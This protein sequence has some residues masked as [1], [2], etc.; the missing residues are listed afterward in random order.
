ATQEEIS[1]AYRRFSRIFHPDKHSSDP[2]KQKWAEQIFNK[3][4]EAYEVLS[5]SHK[6]AIYDTLGK[7]GLEV[8]GWEII[9]RTRTPREI[10]EEYDRHLSSERGWTEV[11]CGI[12]N[13][14]VFGFKLFRTL[15]RLMF[16]NCGTGLQFTSRG[17]VP[18]FVSTMALQLDAHSVGYL[19]YRAGGQAGSSMTSTYV[20]DSEKHHLN[21]AVQIGNPHSFI[22]FNIMRKIPQHDMKLRLALNLESLGHRRD[23]SPLCVFYRLYNGEC[24][25]ESFAL[26]PPSLFYD[27]TSRRRNKFHPHHLD[28]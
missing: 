24:S 12:G 21:A 8:D 1:S 17:I 20:R 4:K 7:R 13:G 27:R 19:T 28:A 6:R 11:E 16:V 14:P 22:S 10:R 3:V 26:I 9:F 5:D 23:V 15:S 25:E 18:S 2:N